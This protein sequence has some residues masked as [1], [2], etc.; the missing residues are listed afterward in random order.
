MVRSTEVSASFANLKLENKYYE[1]SQIIPNLR[2]PLNPNLEF[3]Q[4]VEDL[5]VSTGMMFAEQQVD[6][7]R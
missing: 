7:K 3:Q 5:K 2:L 4:L 6:G 1:I